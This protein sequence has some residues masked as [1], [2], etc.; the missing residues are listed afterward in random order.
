MVYNYDPCRFCRLTPPA[1]PLCD[2]ARCRRPPLR[3]LAGGRS[4]QND[5]QWKIRVA[6][7]KCTRNSDFILLFCNGS[8]V[9]FSYV[10]SGG[11]I[12]GEWWESCWNKPMIRAGNLY[13]AMS[14]KGPHRALDTACWLVLPSG[15]IKIAIENGHWVCGFTRETWWFSTA[16]YMF[17]GE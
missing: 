1:W 13:G 16:M 2:R 7:E 3:S 15:Y 10:F 12:M 17:A 8:F 11:A 5:G 9:W 14:R 6:R 4:L